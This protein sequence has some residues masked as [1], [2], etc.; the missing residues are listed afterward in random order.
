[1]W[2]RGARVALAQVAALIWHIAL[3]LIVMAL[4]GS[5]EPVQL[6]HVDST[7]VKLDGV[8]WLPRADG[9]GRPKG[10]GG[11]GE[12]SRAPATRARLPGRERAS[13]PI[14]ATPVPV[15]TPEPESTPE[16]Q[17]ILLDARRTGS[18]VTT[19]PGVPEPSPDSES[20]GPG[21]GPGAGGGHG[22]GA[23]PGTG[24]G[25]GPGQGGGTG[26]DVY[27]PRQRGVSPPVVIVMEKPRYTAR[28]MQAHVEG[29]VLVECIVDP[30]GRC[31]DARVIR[32]LDRTFGL[33]QEAVKATE[34]WRFR[35][36]ALFGK[37]VPVLIRIEL[38]FAIR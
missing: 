26:D 3:L 29:S 1:M 32:S 5:N 18:D 14:A 30:D 35:P 12:P 17:R 19:V 23:G 13:L 7:T 8:V 28:A 20:R 34:R 4:T 10:G 22:P 37:A 16:T 31:R 15:S 9:N 11:G 38:D 36:G 24:P 2:I 21:D 25:F 6:A 27:D 33:D